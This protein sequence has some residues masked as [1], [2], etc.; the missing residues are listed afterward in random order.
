MF[1]MP[2]GVKIP[3]APVLAGIVIRREGAGRF[4]AAPELADP[5]CAVAPEAPL[6]AELAAGRTGL[7]CAAPAV[8]EA[9]PAEAGWEGLAA[10]YA[11]CKGK[12]RPDPLVEETRGVVCGAAVPPSAAEAAAV[13]VVDVEL[14]GAV[15]EAEVG[16][17]ADESSAALAGAFA[18]KRLT[19]ALSR[20]SAAVL[21][22][23]VPAAAGFGALGAG[24]TLAS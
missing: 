5:G 24:V 3:S 4:A 17:P 21:D 20:S 15:E 1:P 19:G 7:G 8:C 6:A 13:L 16:L 22:A 2:A 9:E 14:D 11:G 12:V 10:G 23:T 18:G